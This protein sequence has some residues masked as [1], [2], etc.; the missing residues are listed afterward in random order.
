MNSA[1]LKKTHCQVQAMKGGALQAADNHY[2][3]NVISS[4]Y[5]EHSCSEVMTTDR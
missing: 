3:L 2:S 4:F 5:Y 1:R